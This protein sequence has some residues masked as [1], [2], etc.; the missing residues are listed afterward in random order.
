MGS[1]GRGRNWKGICISLLVIL[2]VF[3]FIVIAVILKK[4]GMF[5]F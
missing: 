4:K 3:S 2:I 5:N 1:N